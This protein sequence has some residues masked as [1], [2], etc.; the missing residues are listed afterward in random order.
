MAPDPSGEVGTPT[1]NTLQPFDEH[2]AQ[3]G[4][5]ATTGD[6]LTSRGTALLDY[7][8]LRQVARNPAQAGWDG[9]ASAELA[10]AD[11]PVRQ[12]A[13]RTSADLI[14]TGSVV[15]LWAD[16]VHDFNAEVRR[17]IG[18]RDRQLRDHPLVEQSNRPDWPPP[19]GPAD[20]Y[21]RDSLEE[22]D[23]IR[24]AAT[25]RWHAAHNVLLEAQGRA[26]A[27]LRDGPTAANIRML[28]SQGAI[29]SLYTG[30][31]TAYPDALSD[32]I[33]LMT[34]NVGGGH[35]NALW[36][37]DGMDP[38][39]VDELAERIAAGDVDVAT[40]QEVW[41]MDVEELE[42]KLEELTGDD[43]DMHFVQ[44]ST[45]VRCD[46]DLAGTVH[47]DQ[48]FGNLIAVR[49]GDGVAYS[50]LVGT[51]KLDEPGD[52]G[53]DGRAAVSV[54]VYTE[55]GGS[56][57]VAT[58]HTDTSG[59]IDDDEARAHQIEQTQQLAESI[60]SGGPTIVTGDF[61]STRATDDATG[62]ALNGIVQDGY[63]DAGGAVGPTSDNGRGRPIDFVFTSDDLGVSD[64][65]RVNGDSPDK[66]GDDS[67]L[68]D[69]DGI[70][71]DVSVPV[72]AGATPIPDD[73]IPPDTD[74]D[75][76]DRYGADNELD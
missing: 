45:K 1:T 71:V 29:A 54:R 50:E 19:N 35:G 41:Q 11:Q 43:W 24:G 62:D 63:T 65:S 21:T 17:T 70:A 51:E 67:D 56:V 73:E 3:S 15:K 6:T 31:F 7:E 44:A 30:V 76:D 28:R 69:H 49:R 46:D 34:L 74:F 14:W 68:S 13:V 20:I 58:A 18:E 52:D 57:D 22:Q 42:E 12:G 48:P 75:D 66:E 25:R 2:P 47:L 26:V 36:E 40:L 38:G 8:A 53:S 5:L 9:L 39:D 61:N 72:R 4:T 10:G 59:D 16:S 37:S 23:G 27:M 60:A 55:N 32:D 33:R 64:P